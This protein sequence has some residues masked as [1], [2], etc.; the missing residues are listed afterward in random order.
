MRRDECWGPRT[1]ENRHDLIC[2]G[3]AIPGIDATDGILCGEGIEQERLSKVDSHGAAGDD[4][5]LAGMKEQ[6]V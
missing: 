6:T 2:F 4:L 5:R 3:K 1:N